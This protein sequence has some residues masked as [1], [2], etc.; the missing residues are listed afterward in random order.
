M[1]DKELLL[2]IEEKNLRGEYRDYFITKRHNYF[3]SIQILPELWDCFL[4]LDE[5]RKHEFA[6]VERLRDVKHLLPL[7]LFLNSHAQFRVAFELGF[8]TCIAEAWNIVRSAIE[9]T[10]HAHKIF[11]E[12]HLALTWAHK[13]DGKK[14]FQAYRAAFEHNKK[15]NLFPVEYGLGKLYDYYSH[16]SEAGTHATV[17]ALALRYHSERTPT[18]VNITHAYLESD[19]RRV[20]P[21][22]NSMLDAGFLMETACFSCFKERL[23][24][25]VELVRVRAEFERRKAECARNIIRRFNVTPPTIWPS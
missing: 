3:A 10:A 6:D 16:F 12:P 24:L 20:A 9:A 25:D 18:D 11:R 2:P 22:L 23:N 15:E 1:A 19:P 14:E 8:S 5:I 17:T 7:Q 4:E 21:F 13:E